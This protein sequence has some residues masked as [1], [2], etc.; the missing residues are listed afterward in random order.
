MQM[1]SKKQ[2]KREQEEQ[3]KQLSNEGKVEILHKK[4]VKDIISP[5]GIDASNIDHMEII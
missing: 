2:L 4:S 3:L 1:A 5:S